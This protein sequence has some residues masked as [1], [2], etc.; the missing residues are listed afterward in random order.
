MPLLAWLDTRTLVACQC[1]LTSVFAVMLLG[2]RRLYPQLRG[3]GSV[4]LGFAVASPAT[5]LLATR[6]VVPPQDVQRP[7]SGECLIDPR[8]AAASAHL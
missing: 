3:V 8:L 5:L 4:A 6:S 1:L 2:M 7:E